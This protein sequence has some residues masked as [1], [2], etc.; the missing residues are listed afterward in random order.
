[1][2]RAASPLT[3][4]STEGAGLDFLALP[5]TWEEVGCDPLNEPWLFQGTSVRN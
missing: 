4:L 3:A 1:M 5:V 2:G